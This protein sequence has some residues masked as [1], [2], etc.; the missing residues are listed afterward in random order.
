MR[1]ARNTVP[2]DTV[3]GDTERA[4]RRR[5]HESNHTSASNDEVTS[6]SKE[7]AQAKK[8][9]RD[10][11]KQASEEEMGHYWTGSAECRLRRA[12]SATTG[13]TR[14]E[15]NPPLCMC[16]FLSVCVRVYV[17]VGVSV[18]VCWGRA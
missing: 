5:Y 7:P 18:Q 12:S 17:G 10:S 13:D 16:V 3:T 1:T 6:H 15:G 8:S 2:G 9:Q 4:R 11:R 14:A